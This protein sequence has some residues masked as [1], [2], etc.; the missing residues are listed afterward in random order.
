[1]TRGGKCQYEGVLVQLYVGLGIRLGERWGVEISKMMETDG[2]QMTDGFTMNKIYEWLGGLSEWG[3]MQ[4][5]RMC[6]VVY[7][8]NQ[9]VLE[10]EEKGV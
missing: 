3:G 1:M 5:S 10:R 7:Q 4:A 6:Q 9:A 8:F 2:V